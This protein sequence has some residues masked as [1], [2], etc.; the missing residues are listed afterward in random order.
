[1]R[2]RIE[3]GPESIAQ[4]KN[5]FETTH[6]YFALLHL[7]YF[8]EDLSRR[9]NVSR[10][11][12]TVHIQTPPNL[13]YTLHADLIAQA[14]QNMYDNP[15]KS[16]IL[17]HLILLN[18]LRGITM[19]LATAFESAKGKGHSELQ[20]AFQ[21]EVF[22]DDAA[23]TDSFVGITRFLRNVLS[24]NI[25]DELRLR[26]VDYAVQRDYRN[27]KRNKCGP[28]MKFQYRYDDPSSAIHIPGYS[29]GLLIELDLNRLTPGQPFES[30]MSAHQ[31]LLFAEF[32]CNSLLFLY[33][34]HIGEVA[35]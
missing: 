8:F 19:S 9:I 1:M 33:R 11:A 32:C 3:T 26:E 21:T 25:E 28:V 12:R 30:A 2:P 29:H 15:S 4:L 5:A 14:L 7:G 18:S 23:L 13:T 10:L 6:Q 31:S 34:K 22:L 17:S 16:S 35:G 27:N 20:D 24:H